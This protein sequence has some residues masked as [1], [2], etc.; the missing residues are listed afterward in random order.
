MNRRLMVVGL[1]CLV[2]VPTARAAD[3]VELR[4]QFQKGQVLKY[5][6][7]HTEVRAVA[8]ADQKLETTTRMEYEWHLT[9]KDVDSAGV[10]SMDL[11]LAAL[12]VEAAGKDFSF[13]YDS[14]KGNEADTQY[15]KD[16]KNYYDQMRFA[17]FRLRMKPDG[18]VGEVYG[19]DKLLAETA[20]GTQV[21]EFHAY[22]LHD[23]TFAW[24]L[25]TALGLLPEKAVEPD[26]KW[27]LAMPEK[28]KDVGAASGQ[29]DFSLD[30]PAKA[31]DRVL[32]QIKVG[33]SQTVDLNM[34]FINNTMSGQ[35]KTSKL[36]GVVKFDRKAG[37]VEGGE[38]A[39]EY[40]GEL[41]FGT[42]DKP[43]V[44]KVTIKNDVTLERKP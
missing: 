7:K 1:V 38:Y 33:G 30:K 8:V 5:L 9:V 35:L 25:Q 24:Y 26:A 39:S 29:L 13:T 19:F 16:L 32:E 27:K 15:N 28:F 4:W 20:P 2:A 17:N 10:A 42:N 14:A 41:K 23:D 12:R 36:G 3:A 37:L 44:M 31:G 40:G 43:L 21:A 6:L 34:P 22:W 18:R 11:K